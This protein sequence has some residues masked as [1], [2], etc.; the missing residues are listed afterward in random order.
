[1]ELRIQQQLALELF[2]RNAKQAPTV[3]VTVIECPTPNGSD[4]EHTVTHLVSRLNEIVTAT[5][6]AE[7]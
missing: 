3:S 1:M 6:S 7:R 2:L 5:V 4:L